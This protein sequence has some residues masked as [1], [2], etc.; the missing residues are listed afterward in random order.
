MVTLFPFDKG[1]RAGTDR[2]EDEVLFISFNNMLWNDSSKGD[3]QVAKGRAVR[4]IGDD[5]DGVV[6]IDS[7]GVDEVN[8]V[9]NRGGSDRAVEREFYIFRG[10]FSAVVEFDALA[11]VEDI[12]QIVNDI[13]AFSDLREK[14]VG[15]R[16]NGNQC[17]ENLAGDL[18]GRCFFPLMRVQRCDIGTL[19]PGE[20]VLI[21]CA[22]SSADQGK[23]EDDQNE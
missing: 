10:Q 2:V 18:N 6:I 4:C 11:D 21:L 15:S 7:D 14:L 22:G 3:R 13:P 1:V 16:I 9:R 20:S 19:C 23:H 12:S 17:V 8:D 5:G